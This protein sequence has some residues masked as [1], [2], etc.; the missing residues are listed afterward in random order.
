MKKLNINANFYLKV[1]IKILFILIL[2]FKLFSNETL[3]EIKGNIYTDKN[4]IFSLIKDTPNE[5]SEEYSNYLLKTLD[6]SMLF[7]SVKVTIKDN[8]YVINIIEF[9]NINEIKF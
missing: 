1:L 5:I 2:S 3:I 6:N 4:A 7:E 9:P 8:K